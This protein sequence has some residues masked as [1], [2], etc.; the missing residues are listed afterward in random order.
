M[1]KKL[2]ITSKN[3]FIKKTKALRDGQKTVFAGKEASEKR[4]KGQMVKKEKGFVF[5][6]TIP[7][8]IKI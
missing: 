6:K 2:Q 1:N 4:E 7:E 3:S 5:E 8:M